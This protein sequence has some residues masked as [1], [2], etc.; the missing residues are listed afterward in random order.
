MAFKSKSIPYLNYNGRLR[1]N[2]SDLEL[3]SF[4]FELDNLEKINIL[5]YK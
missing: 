2:Y 5:N 4:E 1:T 3:V